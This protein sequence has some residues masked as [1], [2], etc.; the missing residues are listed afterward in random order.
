MRQLGVEGRLVI[1][2][3]MT[4]GMI[5][6]GLLV[7]SATISGHMSPNG[8]LS[9]T[10]LLFAAG[11][12]LGWLHA[13]LLGYAGR[14]EGETCGDAVR[15]ILFGGVCSLPALLVAL[16]A[17]AGIALSGIVVRSG[18]LLAIVAATFCWVTGLAICLWAASVTLEAYRNALVRYPEA[19]LGSVLLGV[20]LF[21]LLVLFERTHPE[22]WGTNYRVTPIGAAILALG[23][24]VW[25]GAPLLLPLLHVV[26]KRVPRRRTQL[27]A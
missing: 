22:I 1:A 2:F 25:I 7:A 17:A 12:V 13:V 6:S 9:T 8:A 24:T 3:T 11:T 4:G 26:Y 20:L 23:V 16:L 21:V 10:C 18:G 14:P 5:V 27:S 15:N 19:R